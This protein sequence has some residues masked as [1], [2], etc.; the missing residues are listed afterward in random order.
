MSFAK[1]ELDWS[2]DSDDDDDPRIK[3]LTQK[4]KQ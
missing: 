2:D 4:A 1:G 3:G